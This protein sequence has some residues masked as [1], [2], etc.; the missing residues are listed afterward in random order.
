MRHQSIRPDGRVTPSPAAHPREW[1]GTRAGWSMV[2]RILAVGYAGG[3]FLPGQPLVRS[4]PDTLSRADLADAANVVAGDL[5]EHVAVV[6]VYPAWYAEPSLRRL[7]TIRAGLDSPQ[8][9]LHA[10]PLPPLAGSVLCALTA[11]VAP[12]VVSAG[13]LVGGLPLLERQLLPIARLRSVARLAHPPP[14]VGQHVASWW[15]PS[16]FGVSWWPRPHV[17]VLGRHD[18]SVPLPGAAE[19]LNVPLDRLAVAGI[20]SDTATW[21][22]HSIV[23][24][25]GVRDVTRVAPEPLAER[26]WGTDAVLE[27]VAH[28]GNVSGLVG[29]AGFRRRATH[30]R[31]CGELV[32]SSVCPYCGV[33]RSSPSTGDAR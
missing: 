25:L 11:A 10:S 17:R 5:D 14:T 2:A 16:A 33:D 22:D 27:A 3:R 13:V 8:L 21:V 30:C 31:W 24:P 19:W 29:G 7:Q 20:G 26:Y 15:P 9:L 4:F 1:G 28:P 18:R 23:A 32:V 6:A 12:H